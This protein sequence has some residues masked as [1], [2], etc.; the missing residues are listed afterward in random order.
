MLAGKNVL[1]M[2]TDKPRRRPI[3]E[4]VQRKDVPPCKY[5][6]STGSTLLDLAISGR[7]PGGVGSGR[8]TQII[9]DNST[10]KSVLVR[11]ILG[12]AQRLGGFAAEEESER[13][14]DFA[15]ADLFGLNVG[16]WAVGPPPSNVDLEKARAHAGNYVYRNPPTLEA[17]FDDELGGFIQLMGGTWG[18]GKKEKKINALLSPLAIGVDTLTALPGLSEVERTIDEASYRMERAKT[19]SEG[20]RKYIRMIGELD[21]T[22]VC[23]D[24]IRTKVGAS[25]WGKQWTTSGGLAMQ[26]YASTRVYLKHVETIKNAHKIAVGVKIAFEVVK[27]K[28]APPFRSGELY[29][30]FDYGIDDIRANL[31]FLKVHQDLDNVPLITVG[32]TYKWGEVK[33]GDSLN[34]AINFVDVHDMAE[35]L[36]AEVAKVWP[37]VHAS[38]TADRKPRYPSL[39]GT[40]A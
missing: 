11:Q 14:P 9:G 28:L 20:F 17:M 31:E 35:E 23:V 37:I 22:M 38:G 3:S 32:S 12:S 33:L 29:V 1:K 27:N 25:A 34:E 8:V 5:Y 2:E 10:A 7:H 4:D 40:P 19:M 36:A 26:Q 24:H 21:I 18:K 16:A 13:T 39:D 15:R 6:L 30:M